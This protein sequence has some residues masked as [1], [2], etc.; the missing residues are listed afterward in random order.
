[1]KSKCESSSSSRREKERVIE[2]LLTSLNQK[3]IKL[4]HHLV[5]QMPYLA[6]SVLFFLIEV[7][8]VIKKSTVL[9]SYNC[10]SYTDN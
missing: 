5:N 10:F 9:H 1:V 8:N 4:K 2:W 6:N 7:T 3:L